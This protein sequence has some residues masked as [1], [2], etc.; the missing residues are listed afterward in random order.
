MKIAVACDGLVIASQA[1]TCSSFTCYGVE[2]GVITSCSNVPNMGLTPHERASILKQMGVDALIAHQFTPEGLAALDEIG[3]E[4]VLFGDSTPREAADAYL[5]R[6]LMGDEGLSEKSI[7]EEPFGEIDDAFAR[8][9]LRLVAQ[10][11]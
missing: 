5:N 11:V 1:A 4:P 9:E 2:N 6:T 10:A 7:K 8:I 3:I